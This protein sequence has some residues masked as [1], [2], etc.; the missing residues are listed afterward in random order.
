M[1]VIISSISVLTFVT[2]M[3]SCI[4]WLK[5][6][7]SQEVSF[8]ESSYERKGLAGVV[9][10]VTLNPALDK[11]VILPFFA[12][13][14]V[15]RIAKMRIDPGG[16]GI[17][18]SKAIQSLGGQSLAMGILGGEPGWYIKKALDEMGIENDFLLVSEPTRTNLKIIDPELHTNTDINEP[19]LPADKKNINC[20]FDRLKEK[21][22]PGD[23][24]V[25]AG[26]APPGVE[27]SIFAQWIEQLHILGAKVYMDADGPLLFHGVTARPEMIKPNDEEFSRMMGRSFRSID[28]IA[29][30]A[31]ELLCRGIEKV[32]VSLG[33]KG[34]LFIRQGSAVYAK[35]LKVPVKSTVGA[36]DTTMAALVL[37][38]ARGDPWE[39]TIP[40][41]LAA[42]AASVMCEGTEAVSLEAVEALIEQVQ[43][44]GL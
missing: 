36:G 5:R 34:A 17:N 37:G 25:L 4:Q 20:I 12:V 7:F 44:E 31:Q 15:N 24:V 14:K 13:G 40:F 26:K 16:K 28:E 10:T 22:L 6:T 27:D 32:V 35:G 2:N 43:L 11:T 1:F 38:D 30:A 3:I 39:K 21:V 8:A 29:A 18:V 42:G 9:I 19:G 33:E 41:A 23:I